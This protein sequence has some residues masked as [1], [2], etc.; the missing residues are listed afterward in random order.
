MV[1]T[2]WPE[3]KYNVIYADPPWNF[4]GAKLNVATEGVEIT[5]HYPLMTDDDLLAL[6]VKAIAD[7]NCLLFMWTVHSKLPFAIQLM[8]AWGFNY[9]TVAFEW[10]KRTSTGKP[11]CFMG[12]WTTGGAIELCLLGRRG[13]VPRVSKTVRRLVDAPRGRHSEKPAEVR[14]RIVSLVGDI[15][16][17]ELFSR[18]EAAGWDAWGN[19]VTSLAGDE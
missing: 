2:E 9:S 8:E 13:S 3:R 18:Q 14:D 10:F 12:K 5:D 6:P 17:I 1:F 7:K 16:R 19:Q 4:G 11:V 15:P